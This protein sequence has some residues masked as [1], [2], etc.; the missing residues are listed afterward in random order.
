MKLDLN[1]CVEEPVYLQT[2]LNFE[3]CLSSSWMGSYE[4]YANSHKFFFK[5]LKLV[6][7]K[8]A[9]VQVCIEFIAIH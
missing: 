9:S 1:R 8:Y 5:N 4:W 3:F 2:H 7:R 6:F